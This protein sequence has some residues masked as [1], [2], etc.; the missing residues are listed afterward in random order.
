MRGL[1]HLVVGVMLPGLAGCGSGQDTGDRCLQIAAE[2]AAA[3]PQARVCTPAVSDSCGAQRPVLVYE[4]HDDG[5]LTL[6]GL[7]HSGGG[8]LNPARVAGLDAILARFSAAGCSL[9]NCPGSL[10]RV[11]AC[12]EDAGG[13]F[14]CK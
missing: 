4:Q 6:D 9:T 7:C 13:T 8:F 2:Y 3:L 1:V 5:R 11:P 12:T 14:T 10:P